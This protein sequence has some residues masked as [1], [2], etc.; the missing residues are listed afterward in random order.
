MLYY[1]LALLNTGMIA[2]LFEIRAPLSCTWSEI[3]V[4]QSRFS[5]FLKIWRRYTG[6]IQYSGVVA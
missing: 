1:G 2:I 3:G 4:H 6:I 5:P